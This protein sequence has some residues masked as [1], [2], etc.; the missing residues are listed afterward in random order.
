MLVERR[1]VVARR[2]LTVLD[3]SLAARYVTLVGVVVPKVESGLSP[4]AMANRVIAS[5]TRPPSFR[6]APWRSERAAFARR[7]SRL[8]GEAPCAVFADVRDCYAAVAPVVVRASLLA[9]GCRVGDADRIGRFLRG[10]EEL[11]VRGLPVGP[12]PSAVLAN[13]VLAGVDRALMLAGFRHLRWVDDFVVRARGARDA[14]RVLAVLRDSLGPLGLELNEAK[15][16]V[17][18]GPAALGRAPSVSIARASAP[19]G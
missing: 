6:L 18:L 15:T 16:R 17:V 11:G 10:L 19:V 5:S 13:G 3:P 14:E 12:E 4:A 7:L 1:P 2:R 8:A 9:L